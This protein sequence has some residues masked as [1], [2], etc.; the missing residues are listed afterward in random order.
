MMVYVGYDSRE[1]EAYRVCRHSILARSP[2]VNIQPLIQSD[3][4]EQGLYTRG[5][6]LLGSTEFTFTRFLVPSLMQYK[7]WALFIDCDF[8]FLE[9]IEN[10]FSQAEE[11]YAVLVVQHDYRPNSRIKMDGKTQYL[12]PRKNWSSLVL[13][14]C[15]HPSNK[16]LSTEVVNTQSGSYLHRFS[17]LKDEEIGSI[18]H[19]WNWLV[20]WYKEPDNGHPKALHY[21][22]GGPWLDNF[23]D[24][25]Y[26]DLWK[27]EY[28][29]YLQTQK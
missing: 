17:W 22:E 12:Y 3:L 10:L 7:G 18:S 1:D 24:C 8:L 23:K 27:K 20:N 11:K 4:R 25:D 21:T 13:W 9:N 5:S 2:T 16:V 26:S 19:E 15:E 29:E 6:D 14:N 28:Y